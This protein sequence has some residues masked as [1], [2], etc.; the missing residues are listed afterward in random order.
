MSGVERVRLEPDKVKR[1][2]RSLMEKSGMAKAALGAELHFFEKAGWNGFYKD[3]PPSGFH[4]KNGVMMPN[5]LN[6]IDHMILMPRCGR[7]ALPAAP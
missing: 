2:S 6:E 3:Y 5:I 4:W 7:H 1:S